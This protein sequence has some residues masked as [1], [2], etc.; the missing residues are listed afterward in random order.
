MTYW[1]IAGPQNRRTLGAPVVRPSA[2]AATTWFARL[3]F[4]HIGFAGLATRLAAGSLAAFLAGVGGFLSVVAEV[5]R[6]RSAFISHD[7][8]PL[9]NVCKA[10]ALHKMGDRRGGQS[11]KNFSD[12]GRT[13]GVFRLSAP[14]LLG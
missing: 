4:I 8:L 10:C 2:T 11:L 1:V 3:V 6:I 12:A 13:V 7:S 14:G 5:S 9:L